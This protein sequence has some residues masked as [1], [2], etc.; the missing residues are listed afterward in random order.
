MV[1]QKGTE[2]IPPLE[3]IPAFRRLSRDEMSAEK[4]LAMLREAHEQVVETRHMLAS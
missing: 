3:S 1:V 2:D 4:S